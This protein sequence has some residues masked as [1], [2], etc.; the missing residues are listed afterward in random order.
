MKPLH[1]QPTENV[2]K[3]K[4]PSLHPIAVLCAAFVLLI[5]SADGVRAATANPPGKLTYQGFLTDGDGL[6]FGDPTPE[7]KTV[8]FRI[9][10]AETGG[11]IVWSSQQVV[12]V[13]KG[14]FSVLLGEGSASSD[15]ADLFDDDLSPYFIGLGASDR[16]LELKVDSTVIAPRL[17]L[18]PAPY[19]FLAMSATEIVDDSGETVVNSANLSITG[20]ASAASLTLTGAANAA[21]F[22]G[23]GASL[24]SLNAT[25][26]TAGTVPNARI[27]GANITS[28]NAGNISSGTLNDNRLSSN[29]PR[30]N[31][32][33]SFTKKF[34]VDNT[35]TTQ[36]S[37]IVWG[38][39]GSTRALQ[40]WRHHDDG[41][42][43]AVINSKGWLGIGTTSPDVP[44]EITAEANY[45][46]DRTAYLGGTGAYGTDNPDSTSNTSIRTSGDIIAELFAV[47]S[48][49]RI[50]QISGRTSGR[51]AL[52]AIR[53]LQV[54]D[55]QYQDFIGRGRRMQRGF[56]AQEVEKIIPEAVSR[57]TGVIP[58]VYTPASAFHFDAEAKELTITV[59]NPHG[60]AKGDVVNLKLTNSNENFKVIAIPSA[61]EFVVTIDAK[62]KEVFVF[63]RRVDDFRTVNYDHIFTTGIS[64]IQELA[65]ENEELK[66]RVAHLESLEE[67]IANL[68][69]LVKQLAGNQPA[70]KGHAKVSASLDQA[71][72][73]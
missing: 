55:Y 32:Q 2:M 31:G 1:S 33:N 35:D 30:I 52:D 20:A 59:E 29:I 37:L 54:T 6:P 61:R 27:D 13:D 22:S 9:Y 21:S 16:F 58:D 42:T 48:D 36:D 3:P 19:A 15:G 73:R 49:A 45:T 72:N 64:A 7:N 60:L 62:P 40:S 47:Q 18:L 34:T 25:Q 57:S 24:T 26:L 8:I 41:N 10:D 66:R 14:H 63:G 17:Q 53:E 4:H 51:T 71:S 5:A 46:Y 44:L 56:I 12:T 69:T 67:Q 39:A 23:S 70:K 11:N 43:K 65:R 38:P 28:I 68:Q 50:K